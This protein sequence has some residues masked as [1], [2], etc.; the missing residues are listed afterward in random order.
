MPYITSGRRLDLVVPGL[1]GAV[2]APGVLNYVITKLCLEY[3]R[4]NKASY[5]TY[6]AIIGVLECVKQ[7]LYRRA[8]APYEDRKLNENGDVGYEKLG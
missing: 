7:E 2:G 6:N 3:L 1:V 5:G 4:I 8:V